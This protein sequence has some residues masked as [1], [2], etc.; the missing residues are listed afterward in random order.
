MPR[1]AAHCGALPQSSGVRAVYLYAFVDSSRWEAL[2]SLTAA[3][4]ALALHRVGRIGAIFSDVPLDE[5]SGP[6]GERNLADPN[7]IMPRIAHHEAVVERA[8]EVSPIF[9][10]RFATLYVNLDSLAVFMRRHE[11][12]IA[13]F[14]GL[15]ADR[16]EWA[17]KIT[18]PLGAPDELE[19][20]AMELL[21]GWAE[22]PPGTRYLRLRREQGRLTD[23]ARERAA[24]RMAPFVDRLLLPATT[25]RLLPKSSRPSAAGPQHVQDYALLVPAGERAQLHARF[26]E[27][28]TE[29]AAFGMKLSLTGPWPPYS[30]RPLLEGAGLQGN[31]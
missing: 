30:F 13:D 1:D 22:C 12:A 2:H 11:T 8:M 7:W 3:D 14:F 5:F 29:G 17:F 31:A 18:V 10:A 27:L 24:G 20:L 28:A 9:P 15:V 6:E 4:G 16:Q 23:V 19:S 21:P 26:C 25:M